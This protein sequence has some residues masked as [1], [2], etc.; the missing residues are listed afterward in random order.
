MSKISSERK[1]NL[2]YNLYEQ[3]YASPTACN[4]ELSRKTGICR[5]TTS[6]YLKEMYA[7]EIL[8]P[9]FFSL[10]SIE[11]YAEY[12][13]LLHFENTQYVSPRL[14]SFP[15]VVTMIR[16]ALDWT[17][18]I[19]T[20]RAL[21]FQQLMHLRSQLFQGKKERIIT[22]RCSLHRNEIPSPHSVPRRT[23][24]PQQIIPW[25][26]EE[27]KLYHLFHSDI[28]TTIS[29]LLMKTDI[30][31]ETFLQ[32]K[33]T[34]HM[35]TTAHVLFYPH[36]YTAYTHWYFLLETGYDLSVIF[37]HWPASCILI[38][39]GTYLLLTVPVSTPPQLHTL[40]YL[41][42]TLVDESVITSWFHA[43]AFDSQNKI[44]KKNER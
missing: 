40:L 32:W 2:Y 13:S 6:K 34:L 22:P 31:Y 3:L 18:L 28:N 7:Q 41:L 8:I 19:V 33:K 39:L 25:N 21:H 26:E 20:T 24:P 17:H 1:M 23:P 36:G 11:P 38:E 27:W 35:Y 37:Q 9:P 42:E 15:S 29:P 4:A 12:I 30:G 10:K 44:H 43:V 5:N 14:K 16:C